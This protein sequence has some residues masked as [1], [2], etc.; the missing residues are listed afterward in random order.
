MLPSLQSQTAPLQSCS[1]TQL[2]YWII[3]ISVVTSVEFQGRKRTRE[4]EQIAS[5]QVPYWLDPLFI[6]SHCTGLVNSILNSHCTLDEYR[7]F[8]AQHCS[9]R[10]LELALAHEPKA[11]RIA[12]S[13]DLCVLD[14]D[15]TLLAHIPANNTEKD[16]LSRR[17]LEI[18]N[19]TNPICFHTLNG[20]NIL[21]DGPMELI[22]VLHTS[23]V[24]VIIYSLGAPPHV[25][26][27]MI[28]MEIVHNYLWRSHEF[29]D[30]D[31]PRTFR[32]SGLVSTHG[33]ND[34]TKSF[35]VLLR[36]GYD[37][38]KYQ[39]VLVV[40]D[41]HLKVWRCNNT[42]N[43]ESLRAQHGVKTLKVSDGYVF[44]N[45]LREDRAN[46]SVIELL[47][48]INR[49]RK[50]DTFLLNVADLWREVD[51][52]TRED[53]DRADTLWVNPIL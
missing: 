29:G 25:I 35:D 45:T 48:S 47:D 2:Y 49:E 44:G 13:T 24:E 19:K 51:H 34:L 12:Q 18:N 11:N 17:I 7:S 15:H 27:S 8:L 41:Q 23:S 52:I 38:R 31:D 36:H 16:L 1:S 22:N 53:W 32:F 26:L 39:R 33:P 43:G 3:S 42:V 9:T 46:K 50:E 21:R 14:L 37:C 28:F 40:D 5:G 10:Y 30:D 20:I 4:N 6:N